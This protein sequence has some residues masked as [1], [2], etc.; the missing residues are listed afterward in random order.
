M[1]FC[2]G[3]G[4][5]KVKQTGGE[6]KEYSHPT[7]QGIIEKFVMMLCKKCGWSWNCAGARQVD[8]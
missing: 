4:S 3:C 2:P 6:D 7:A 1:V 8:G 5:N